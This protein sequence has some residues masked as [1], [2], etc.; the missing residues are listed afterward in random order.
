MVQPSSEIK[1]DSGF[2]KLL[3]KLSNTRLDTVYPRVKDRTQTLW[4]T[5]VTVSETDTLKKAF[6][7]MAENNILCVPVIGAMNELVGQL[8]MG[9][10]LNWIVVHFD[11]DPNLATMGD[12]FKK[13]K[14]LNTTQ[15]DV[16]MDYN[17]HVCPGNF[18][19]C[20]AAETMARENAK[21]VIVTNWHN[22]VRGIFTM[23]M[24]VGEIYNNLS[25]LSTEI[26]GMPVRKMTKSY[27][28][29]RVRE[30]SRVIDAFRIM[31]NWG[32]TGL[33]VT[34][35]NGTIVDELSEK[36]LKAITASADS[37][38]RLYSDV[39][40]FKAFVREDARLQGQ[41]IPA[42]PQ[43]VTE[44]ATFEQC[45]VAMDQIP[46]HRIFVVDDLIGKRPMYVISQTDILRQIFPSLGWW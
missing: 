7:K 36:D 17:V 35:T 21:R 14:L 45:I 41:K 44:S 20:R 40:E 34:N 42:I 6:N 23:S 15:V 10:L 18:S 43:L 33:A 13:G 32:C 37:Y 28:V 5:A 1:G 11:V 31:N 26:R 46:C 4:F 24:M 38:M 3:S 9:N 8:T 16:C 19:V 12:F 2:A 25:L 27:W 39:K 22:E 30:D 29:S